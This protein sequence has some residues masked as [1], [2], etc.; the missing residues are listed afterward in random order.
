[1][2]TGGHRLAK[3]DSYSLLIFIL[4]LII[5]IYS[6]IIFLIVL[7]EMKTSLRI[8]KMKNLDLENLMI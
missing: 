2:S 7:M 6:T 1:M 4:I 3:V 5:L 8:N